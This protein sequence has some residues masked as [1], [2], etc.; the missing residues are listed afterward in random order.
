MLPNP[1]PLLTEEQWKFVE[2]EMKRKPIKEEIERFK[3]I[4]KKIKN[5]KL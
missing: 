3:R 5:F 2:K 1:I 4:R